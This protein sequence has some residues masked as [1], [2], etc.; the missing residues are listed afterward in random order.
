MWGYILGIV[1]VPYFGYKCLIY[2][3]NKRMI[4]VLKQLGNNEKAMEN[5]LVQKKIR[6]VIHLLYVD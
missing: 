2:N 1:A 4:E 3:H 6:E 5:A